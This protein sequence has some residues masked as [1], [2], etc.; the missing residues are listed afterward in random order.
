MSWIER[1]RATEVSNTVTIINIISILLFFIAIAGYLPEKIIQERYLVVGCF[2][3]ILLIYYLLFLLH[4]R[5]ALPARATMLA[6]GAL[7]FVLVFII[8]F[9][10][11]ISGAQRSD[12]KSLYF[13]PVVLFAVSFGKGMGFAAAF[14]SLIG[15]IISDVVSMPGAAY[16]QYLEHDLVLIAILFIVAWLVGD[17]VDTERR[18]RAKLAE[19][20]NLDEV[21]SLYNHRR[22]Q[23]GLEEEVEK[24]KAAGDRLSLIFLDIDYFK[25]YNDVFG[26]QQGDQALYQVGEVMRT[27]CPKYSFLARYGGDEFVVILPKAGSGEAVRVAE[28]IRNA[29]EEHEFFGEDVQPGGV[30]SVSVGVA[31]LPDHAS[32]KE[33]LLKV[34]DIALYKAK[35]E[36]RNKV[37]LYFSVL[38]ELKAELAESELALISTLKTLIYLVNAKDRYTYGHSERVM[39]YATVLGREIGLSEKEISNLTYGGFL[40]DVGKIEISYEILNKPGPLNDEEWDVIKRHPEWGAEIVRPVKA[41]GAAVPIILYHHERYDGKGYPQGLKGEEIPLGARVLAICD[42]FDAMWNDRPYQEAKTLPEIIQEFEMCAG[43]QFDPVLA[44]RFIALLQEGKIL[45]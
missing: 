8:S 22:F 21:T 18:I 13:I 12:L 6:R 10:V 33:E 39:Q 9:I 4:P 43:K 35:F 25:H 41:L 44:A 45:N 42:S 24:A 17:L 3:I 1:E 28:R 37:E 2:G 14:A 7:L 5:L 19:Q 31:T 32:S 40:H 23:E 20:A 15:L 27:V 38:D 11:Y 30:M 29:V 16:N 34:A 36:S 26:H